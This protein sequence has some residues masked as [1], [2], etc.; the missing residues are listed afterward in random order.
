MSPILGIYASQISGHLWA[1]TGAYESIA[2][3]TPTGSTYFFSF[4][5]IPQTY[6]HLQIR[7]LAAD[8]SSGDSPILM[9]LNGDGGTNYTWHSLYGN[10]SSATSSAGTANSA[11]RI[12]QTTNSGSIFS[13]GI[14]DILDYTNTNKNKVLRS[15]SGHDNN[16]SGSIY[17]YS[18]LWQNTAA[19]T[20]I[21]FQAAGGN[22][23]NYSNFAL[24]GIK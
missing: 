21:Y 8:G 4:T 11:M 2:T 15:L 7:L 3:A 14:I 9:Q 17:L 6:T 22:F 16:G 1:P 18:G 20:S 10:G 23:Q 12:A 24:Y 19:I 5:S 13:G